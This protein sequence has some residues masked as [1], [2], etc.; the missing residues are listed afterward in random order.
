MRELIT[1]P[2]ELLREKS[3]PV[4]NI[5]SEIKALASDMAE[6]MRLNQAK[7]L[8]PVGLSAVQLGELARMFAFYANPM[9]E[10]EDIQFLLNPELVYEKGK[11]LVYESCLSIPGKTFVLKRAKI[12]KIRGLTLDGEE[13]SFRGHELLAQVFQHE[14]NHLDGILIDQLSSAPIPE[15]VQL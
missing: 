9:S 12:V 10:D 7:K 3:K 4:V 13:R 1:L 6:F 8:R 11:R 5:D 14:L 15:G 2:N